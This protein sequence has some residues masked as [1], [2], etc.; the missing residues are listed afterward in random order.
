VFYLCKYLSV[1]KQVFQFLLC[2]VLSAGFCSAQPTIKATASSEMKDPKIKYGAAQAI[3]G[4]LLTWWTPAPP[5]NDGKGSWLKISFGGQKKVSAIKVIGGSHYPNYP[6]LGNLFPLN[7]RLKQASVE[8]E[9]GNS[10]PVLLNDED[11]YQV[12]DF[13][14]PH[15]SSYII[16]KPGSIYPGKKWQDLCISEVQVTF[17]EEGG[18]A[19]SWLSLLEDN[20]GV[21]MD[22]APCPNLMYGIKRIRPT[23]GGTIPSYVLETY[24]VMDMGVDTIVDAKRDASGYVTLHLHQKEY[25]AA[26]QA[27]TTFGKNFL[28]LLSHDP[29]TGDLARAFINRFLVGRYTNEKDEEV[30]VGETTIARGGRAFNYTYKG[31]NDFYGLCG[32][33]NFGDGPL[34]L[35]FKGRDLYLY[36]VHPSNDGPD[37]E[38]EKMPYRVY[39]RKD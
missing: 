25:P 20:I 3:D 31:P 7:A 21:W 35:Q 10:E 18:D 23:D 38:V 19:F 9:D 4:D 32:V 37:Y 8:F 15:L 2:G 11:A 6:G 39:Y 34:Q 12:F 30:I 22:N 16:L 17:E 27:P 14:K 28:R 26:N 13:P 24:G 33:I 5:N 1:M 36:K 29:E